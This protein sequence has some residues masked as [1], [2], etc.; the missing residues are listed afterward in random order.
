MRIEGAGISGRCEEKG[1]RLSVKGDMSFKLQVKGF[2]SLLP[3]TR[4]MSRYKTAG[5]PASLDS[6][7]K[8]GILESGTDAFYRDQIIVRI[9]TRDWGCETM[10]RVM[11]K[12]GKGVCEGQGQSGDG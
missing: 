1:N 7:L 10:M 9:G 11:E 3:K 5:C 8:S 6:A 4:V 2:K 12:W